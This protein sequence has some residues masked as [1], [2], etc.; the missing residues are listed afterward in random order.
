[1]KD[2][3]MQPEIYPDILVFSGNTI[4]LVDI[5]NNVILIEDIAHALSNL[6]RFCGHIREFYSVA[7][8]SV[9]VSR[10]VSPE[11]AWAA[12]FHDA[13]E[14]YLGD[15]SRPLKALLPDYQAIEKRFEAD[16][17]RKLCLPEE[18]PDEVKRADTTL[19]MTEMRDLMPMPP[20]VRA[21][22]VGA[23]PRGIVPLPPEDA[24]ELFV[25]RA[26]EINNA[27]L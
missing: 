1:V 12:L 14:A 17:F 3:F 24:F 10:I 16:I 11:N 25:N 13:G 18:I 4:N 9:L 2:A 26:R 5:A 7:Q 27:G 23:L 6:C 22:I 15:V 19:L 20:A 8:H 21:G